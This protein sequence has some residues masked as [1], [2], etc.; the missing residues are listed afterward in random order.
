M[1]VIKIAIMR[2]VTLLVLRRRKLGSAG[3]FRGDKNSL[4]VVRNKFARRLF[5][6]SHNVIL[7]K[8]SASLRVREDT[9]V[10]AST[11]DMDHRARGGNKIR[12][13]DVMASFFVLHYPADEFRE[14]LIR[15]ALLHACVQIMVPH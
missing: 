15:I 14:F 8:T 5:G 2:V 4:V 7:A 12:L 6:F 11:A 13:A 3:T 1:L 10:T 9:G